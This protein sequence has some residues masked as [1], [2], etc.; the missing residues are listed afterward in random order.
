[1]PNDLLL[2]HS[3]NFYNAKYDMFLIS[4]KIL[5]KK[6]YI[7]RLKEYIIFFRLPIQ[8][9]Q[10]VQTNTLI[11]FYSSSIHLTRWFEIKK[12]TIH[13]NQK[14]KKKKVY[15]ER[16]K[17]FNGFF[18]LV[19]QPLNCFLILHLLFLLVVYSQMQRSFNYFDIHKNI[20]SLMETHIQRIH[21]FVIS[22]NV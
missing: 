9:F 20:Y 19:D 14:F 6:N 10:I 1:M 4:C 13:W 22:I 15:F 5:F 7:F 3:T 2:K 21:L 17:Q 16:S 18:F 12:K 11:Q 8:V